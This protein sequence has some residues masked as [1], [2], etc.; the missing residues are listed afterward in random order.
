MNK[1][2]MLL[3][4]IF[5]SSMT[6]SLS[7]FATKGAA[8]VAPAPTNDSYY[9]SGFYLGGAIGGNQYLGN[10]EQELTATYVETFD[11][12]LVTLGNSE[13]DYEAKSS[14]FT[15]QIQ[16]GYAYVND[17]FFGALEVSGNGAGGAD[18]GRNY[19]TKTLND[20]D[21]YIA[22][23]S[24]SSDMDIELN[25]F[26]PV[27]DLKLG[28]R[29]TP[30]SLLY[31]RVGAAFNE[32]QLKDT[33][34]FTEL[35]DIDAPFDGIPLTSHLDVSESKSVVGLRLGVGGEHRFT[36]HLAVTLDYIYTDYGSVDVSGVADTAFYG[37]CDN[38]TCYYDDGL[39]VS[40]EV[41][42]TRNVVML[43]MNYYF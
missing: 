10:T 1:N 18:F 23:I 2:L 42:V 38:F 28:F 3:P 25:N 12:L 27:V 39:F 40:D 37:P 8:Y 34:T 24:L 13:Q 35:T 16:L 43:G 26:E 33:V 5:A 21:G 36:Q 31:A 30:N 17:W 11:F 19:E 4:L 20:A 29:V 9:H 6:V 22:T 7:A 32:I 14:G 41:D 15:G